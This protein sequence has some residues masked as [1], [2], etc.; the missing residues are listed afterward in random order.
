MEG[1][2]WVK[3]LCDRGEVDQPCWLECQRRHGLSVKAFCYRPNPD[4]PVP[5]CYCTWP[6]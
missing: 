5:Y 1:L 4:L 3:V 6:C 2:P